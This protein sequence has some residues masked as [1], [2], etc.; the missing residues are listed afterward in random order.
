MLQESWTELI[1]RDKGL[2]SPADDFVLNLT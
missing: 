2:E 1:G